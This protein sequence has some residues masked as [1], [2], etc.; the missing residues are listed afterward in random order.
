[1]S[2]NRIDPMHLCKYCYA[3]VPDGST[4]CHRCGKALEPPTSQAPPPR[5][6]SSRSATGRATCEKC[7]KTLRRWEDVFGATLCDDCYAKAKA[8]TMKDSFH[9]M[10][11]DSPLTGDE[12]VFGMLG[13]GRRSFR[14]ARIKRRLARLQLS[15]R[16]RFGKEVDIADV[17]PR[18]EVPVTFTPVSCREQVLV[19]LGR[20]VMVG[21]GF[22]VALTVYG[23]VR[24]DNLSAAKTVLMFPVGTVAGLVIAGLFNFIPAL[25]RLESGLVSA[26]VHTRDG[27]VLRFLLRPHQELE[28]ERVL[29]QAGLTI[30]ERQAVRA[31]ERPP[32]TKPLS[33]RT[34]PACGRELRRSQVDRMIGNPEYSE[35]CREGFC[36]LECFEKRAG[37]AG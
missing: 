28:T 25:C 11:P 16:D 13:L 23:C 4:E 9:C 20:T 3:R 31:S 15:A 14:E 26:A 24:G 37:Q 33:D 18:K 22:G 7:G 30:A 12:K 5:K 29:R 32:E 2:D 27:G 19:A 17:V 34:C 6:A 35:W 36:S 21:V 1:M 8:E 10:I